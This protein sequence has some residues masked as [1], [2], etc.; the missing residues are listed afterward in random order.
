MRL[1]KFTIIVIYICICVRNITESNFLLHFYEMQ[2]NFYRNMSENILKKS[3]DIL[4]MV[5]YGLRQHVLSRPNLSRALGSKDN[6]F[7]E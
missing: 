6:Y 5:G 1:F 4:E 2:I 3:F 7:A